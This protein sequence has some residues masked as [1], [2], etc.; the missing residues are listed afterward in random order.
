MKEIND[1]NINLDAL[2]EGKPYDLLDA[3]TQAYVLK[4]FGSREEYEAMSSSFKRI[5]SVINEEEEITADA[6]VKNDLLALFEE[7][8][9]KVIPLVPKKTGNGFGLLRSPYFQMAVAASLV[10]VALFFV[11]WSG[12]QDNQLALNNSSNKDVTLS[13]NNDVST[14]EESAMDSG[15]RSNGELNNKS[16]ISS[17]GPGEDVIETDDL[18]DNEVEAKSDKISLSEESVKDSKPEQNVAMAPAEEEATEKLSKEEV[19]SSKLEKTTNTLNRDN[20]ASKKGEDDRKQSETVSRYKDE[21]EKGKK[22][23]ASKENENR[24]DAKNANSVDMNS[25]TV[26]PSSVIVSDK[27]AINGISLDE[28]KDLMQFFNTAL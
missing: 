1:K 9:R 6:K 19:K 18:A 20:V 16:G 28:K 27:K 26:S 4:E 12:N 22:K 8:D 21:D 3:H 15:T 2:F 10:I 14:V 17:H 7:E 13:N 24:E 5:R 11:P 23:S 25:G